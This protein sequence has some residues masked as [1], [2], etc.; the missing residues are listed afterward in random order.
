MRIAFVWSVLVIALG[1]FMAM[2]VSV[3][4]HQSLAPTTGE[5][6]TVVSEYV[7]TSIPWI[8]LAICVAPA[9]H[10]VLAAG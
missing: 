9:V 3:W 1:V 8:I 7:W 5:S 4:R 2:L 10:E 6:N